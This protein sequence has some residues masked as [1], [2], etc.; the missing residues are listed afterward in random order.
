[1][2]AATYALPGPT[3]VSTAGTVLVP[4][5]SAAIA[6]AP[7]T[8]KTCS[9]TPATTIAAATAGFASRERGGVTTTIRPTPAT[10]AGIAF[11]RTD[12]G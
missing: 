6:C 5:A 10:L 11:M 7:P 9:S 2:A 8:R 4:W 1:L 12:E 3:I